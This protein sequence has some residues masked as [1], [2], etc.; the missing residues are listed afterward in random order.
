M[1]FIFV[2]LCADPVVPTVNA[3]EN[4][5]NIEQKQDE[6]PKETEQQKPPSDSPESKPQ[7]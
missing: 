7:A 2:F 1:C 3:A 6:K 5:T 4:Q